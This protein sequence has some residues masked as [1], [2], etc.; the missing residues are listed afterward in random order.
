MRA[1]MLT[2]ALLALS[3]AACDQS[4]PGADPKAAAEPAKPAAPE[5]LTSGLTAAEPCVTDDRLDDK[6][7]QFQQIRGQVMAAHA[8]AAW[9][10]GLLDALSGSPARA[11][12]AVELLDSSILPQGREIVVPRLLDLT[13]PERPLPLRLA[14]LRV[15]AGDTEPAVGEKA[16][17]LLRGD[18]AIEVRVQAAVL[19]GQPVH[20]RGQPEAG[21]ALLEAMAKDGAPGVRRA[22]AEALGTLRPPGAV[23]S[24]AGQLDDPLTG[25]IAALALARFEER[26]AYDAIVSRLNAAAEAGQ[27][28]PLSI[29]AA[30]ARLQRHP[31]HDGAAVKESL[32]KIEAAL[33][34]RPEDDREAALSLRMIRRQLGGG[35]AAEPATP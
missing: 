25:P 19:L 1:M 12:V 3:L 30:L 10:T 24:L 35:A 17:A 9:R 27:A 33:T 15:L 2:T 28:P 31:N 29:L 34:A 22:A 5:L 11:L 8:D 20:G 26:A 23:A 16:L 6:C 4:K 21:A 7:A 14:A 32:Q 18:E 13:A